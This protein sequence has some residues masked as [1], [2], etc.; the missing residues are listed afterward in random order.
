MQGNKKPADRAGVGSKWGAR[1]SLTELAP[2]S[3]F[4]SQS[5]TIACPLP[6]YS[7]WLSTAKREA[8]VAALYLPLGIDECDACD[9]P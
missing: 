1:K 8:L 3:V 9:R 2:Q 6:L 4:D 7:Q 5:E